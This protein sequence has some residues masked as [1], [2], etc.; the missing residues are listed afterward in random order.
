MELQVDHLFAGH[1]PA[2]VF[3]G[4]QFAGHHLANVVVGSRLCWTCPANVFLHSKKE[5][6][7]LTQKSVLNLC[8]QF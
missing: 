4:P 7:I 2:N 6:V 1:H 8:L 5:C 3:L